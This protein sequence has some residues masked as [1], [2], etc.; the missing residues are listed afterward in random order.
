MNPGSLSLDS[1]QDSTRRR[2]H[3][4]GPS[5]ALRS[6][7]YQACNREYLDKLLNI[8]RQS[9]L[10]GKEY[11]E[12]YLLRLYRKN[13]RPSTL[14]LNHTSI[15]LFLKF[16]RDNHGITHPDN[17]TRPIIEAFVEHEQDRGLKP[18]SVNGRLISVYAFLGF[19]VENGVIP[20]DVLRK[21]VRV[22]IPEAL[23]RAI[24]PE[25]IRA[26]LA[27]IDHVR[28]RAMILMLLRTGMRIGELLDL[29]IPEINLREKKV[30]IYEAQKT[31]VGRIVYFS[32]DGKEALTAWLKA[33]D[34]KRE[35]IFYAQGRSRLTYAGAR[36][37]FKKYL[38]SA[39]LS[40]KGYTIHCLRHTFASELLNAG[41]RLECL[42]NLLGH[43]NLEVTRRYARL[44]DR[45]REDEYFRAMAII[46]EGVTGGHYRF[47]HKLQETP[48]EEK[49]L[50]PN[51]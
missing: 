31:R 25:D 47:D 38:E 6:A 40:A 8:F 15:K 13:C 17:V 50:T 4:P 46:E 51:G 48:E 18:V 23:P 11:A 42:Q 12:H 37:R 39:G 22:K 16:V 28:D 36:V 20:P 7:P 9:Q 32:D 3:P 26:L 33:R 44:T 14:A 35:F 21:K 45:T 24:D 10:P 2:H 49:L 19:L 27:A 29:K 43:T 41:L 30:I 1:Q 5:Q 34:P